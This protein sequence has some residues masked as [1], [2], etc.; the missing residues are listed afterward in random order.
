MRGCIEAMYQ[1][2]ISRG[3]MDLGRLYQGRYVPPERSD[4]VVENRVYFEH[5]TSED[6]NVKIRSS[7]SNYIDLD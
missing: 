6:I 3:Y 1:G 2:D 7:V 5:I 4:G